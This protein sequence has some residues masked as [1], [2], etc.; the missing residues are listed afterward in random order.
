MR[1]LVLVPPPPPTGRLDLNSLAARGV[2]Y[3][4]RRLRR[5]G[6]DDPNAAVELAVAAMNELTEGMHALHAHD[7]GLH[8]FR[9]LCAA[10][11]QLIDRSAGQA[12]KAN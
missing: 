8:A 6:N 12:G 5:R 1:N 10:I 4:A 9:L 11:D 3:A 2:L 7:G